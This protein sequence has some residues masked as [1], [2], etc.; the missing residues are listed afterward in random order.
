MK[1][2]KYRRI[3][4]CKAEFMKQVLPRLFRP[5]SPLSTLSLCLNR[6]LL[7]YPPVPLE[8]EVPVEVLV[9]TELAVLLDVD[10]DDLL[11]KKNNLYVSRRDF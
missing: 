7:P 8:V 2:L 11:R 1:R 3:C 6:L 5:H 9:K 4:T 10:A